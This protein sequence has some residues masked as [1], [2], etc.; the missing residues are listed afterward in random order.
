[1]KQAAIYPVSG[2]FPLILESTGFP[3]CYHVHIFSELFVTGDTSHHQVT[4]S[5]H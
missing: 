1:M 3:N 4:S 5:E 2:V